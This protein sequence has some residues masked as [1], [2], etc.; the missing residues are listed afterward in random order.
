MKKNIELSRFQLYFLL[1]FIFIG[2]VMLYQLLWFF[3]GTTMAD[4]SITSNDLTYKNSIINSGTLSYRYRVNEKIY[5]DYT[6]RNE[7]PLEQ[8]EIEVKYLKFWP[9][10]SRVNTFEDNWLGFMITYC[11]FFV[12]SSIFLLIDNDTIPN[13][14]YFYF[15][16]KKPWINIITK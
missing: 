5:D 15:T 7:V 13:R 16:K 4:C 8:K 9:S 14:S 12:F 6:T 11:L 1:Q 10:M 3:G 2:L